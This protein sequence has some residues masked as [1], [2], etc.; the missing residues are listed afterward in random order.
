M[1][2]CTGA[3]DRVHKVRKVREE[4][5]KGNR[6]ELVFSPKKNK[7]VSPHE[8]EALVQEVLAQVQDV[9]KE[10]QPR[11]VQGSQVIFHLQGTPSPPR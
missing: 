2:W 7:R 4:L 3:A 1:S 5:E 6:V 11:E 9:M 10:W 8:M